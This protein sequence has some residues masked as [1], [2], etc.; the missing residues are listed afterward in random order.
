MV[1]SYGKAK[2]PDY[3][4]R[5]VP[6]AANKGHSLTKMVPALYLFY[7][8]S[9]SIFKLFFPIFVYFFSIFPGYF[10]KLFL[11]ILNLLF[12]NKK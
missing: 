12:W 6:C 8:Y 2:K 1:V 10:L 11:T 4:T 7:I 9:I 5:A 3:K